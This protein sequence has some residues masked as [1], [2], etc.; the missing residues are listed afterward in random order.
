MKIQ[1]HIP[2]CQ[3]GLCRRGSVERDDKRRNSQSK[4]VKRAKDREEGKKGVR[5]H[6]RADCVKFRVCVTEEE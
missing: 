3:S 4:V 1:Y 2:V 6:E 5:E